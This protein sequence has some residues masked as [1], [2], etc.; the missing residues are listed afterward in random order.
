MPAQGGGAWALVSV[1]VFREE[2]PPFLLGD[3][4]AETPSQAAGLVGVAPLE[5]SGALH[6]LVQP[7]HPGL[8]GAVLLP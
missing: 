6:W 5:N 2:R 8:P 1:L 7:S 3:T 4:R